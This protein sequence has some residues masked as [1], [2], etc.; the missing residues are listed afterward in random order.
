[1]QLSLLRIQRLR[2]IV[3]LLALAICA[4]TAQA[5]N[6]L[7]A[8]PS[9][10]TLTC[11]TVTGPGTATVVI[12]TAAKPTA[13][14]AVSLGALPTGVT[15]TPASGTLTGTN[16]ATGITFTLGMTASTGGA[17]AGCATYPVS[18]TFNF[19]QGASNTTD[20]LITVNTA[21]NSTTSG[22]V[23]SPTR[24]Q[25]DVCQNRLN[26]YSGVRAIRFGHVRCY[27]WRYSFHHDRRYGA[28]V[29]HADPSPSQ[30]HR[31]C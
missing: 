16:Y 22:L 27:Q 15:V 13:S 1:M 5:A 19:K 2:I 30:H 23:V 17:T 28:S 7:V 11:S 24:R 18:G 26:L 21:L 25:P 6:V 12:T 29:A 20:V 9:T 8:T 4:G 10:V 31:S 14:L 3:T